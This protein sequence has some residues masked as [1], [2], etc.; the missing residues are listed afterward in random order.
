MQDHGNA[1]AFQT[2]QPHW[3]RT[4]W[5]VA[6]NTNYRLVVTVVMVVLALAQSLSAQILDHFNPL[7]GSSNGVHLYGAS[8]STIYSTGRGAGAEMGL[9]FGPQ[10]SGKQSLTM[11]QGSVAFGWVRSIAKSSL[12][13]TYSPSY[14]R[15]MN[16]LDYA[17]TNHNLAVSVSRNLRAK[18]SLGGSVTGVLSDFNQLLFA[19]SRSVDLV[20][21]PATFDDFAAA[22]LTGRS[23]DPVLTQTINAAPVVGSPETA[24]LYGGRI[25]SV[26]AA[27]T[28]SYAYSSRS[29]LSLSMSTTRTQFF[30][31]GTSEAGGLGR[32]GFSVPWTTSGTP[33][34]NWG[35]SLTPRTTIGASLTTSRTVSQYQDAYSHQT[36]MS[37]GHTMSSRWFVQGTLGVG[38]IKPVRQTF[39]PNRGPQLT[40]GGGIGYKVYAHTLVASMNRSVSD[41]YGLG[42]NATE[43]STAAWAWKRPGQSISLTSSFGYSRLVGPTFLNSRSWTAAVGAGKALNSQMAISASYSYVRFPTAVASSLPDLTRSGLSVS[44]S[45][46]PSER[47]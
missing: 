14:V 42:A 45:W 37:L 7:S 15:G 41:V 32:T 16:G 10:V 8:V 29:S 39:Q 28:V 22:L 35:Y 1:A 44:L 20:A 43:S 33:S 30:S 34:L 5:A 36:G 27:G 11:M 19:R 18:W 47:R 9:P 21:I 23:V 17:S 38:W 12:S 31:H 24:F 4:V 2:L 46:S 3:R 26:S 25:F 6:G 13:V 40:Y